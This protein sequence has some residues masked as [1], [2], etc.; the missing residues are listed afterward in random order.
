APGVVSQSVTDFAVPMAGATLI[1]TTV[2]VPSGY[3]KAAVV[4]TGRVFATNPGASDYLYARPVVNG[5]TGNA[6]P[7]QA[8][9][10]VGVLNVAPIALALTGLASSFTVSLWASSSVADW[11]PNTSNLAD[12]SGSVVWFK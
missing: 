4:L 7:V 11:S 10:G 2:T 12:L 9:T 6:V 5:T 8:P 1:T 3:T